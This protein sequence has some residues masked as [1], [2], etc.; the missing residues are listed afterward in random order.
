MGLVFNANRAVNTVTITAIKARRKKQ[1]KVGAHR[2][3]RPMTALFA[4]DPVVLDGR[5]DQSS[6]SQGVCLVSA[7]PGYD[8]RLANVAGGP[9]WCALRDQSPG[10]HGE[11]HRSLA[12]PRSRSL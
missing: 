6:R 4:R 11:G 8:P 5:R 9:H 2:A 3:H 7:L 10:A 12:R 1:V